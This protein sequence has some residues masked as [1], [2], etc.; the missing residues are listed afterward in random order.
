MRQTFRLFSMRTIEIKWDGNWIT[1]TDSLLHTELIAQQVDKLYVPVM[2]KCIRCD[3]HILIKAIESN[4]TQEIM[5][6]DENISETK[7]ASLLKNEYKLF[8][9]VLPYYIN[10]ETNTKVTLGLEVE[11]VIGKQF[12]RNKGTESVK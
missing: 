9:S 11:N 12:P 6:K 4:K 10:I 7:M 3:P 1:F 5:T 2:I 8:D